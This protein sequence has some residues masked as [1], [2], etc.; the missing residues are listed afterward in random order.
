[1]MAA[2]I[3]GRYSFDLTSSCAINIRFG[4]CWKP[5]IGF[6][7]VLYGLFSPLTVFSAAKEGTTESMFKS[8][9]SEETPPL[10]YLLLFERLEARR[11]LGVRFKRRRVPLRPRFVDLS[12]EGFFGGSCV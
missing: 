9:L 8:R 11:S 12:F 7:L 2:L 3:V 4:D 1:M 10:P 6:P 5:G